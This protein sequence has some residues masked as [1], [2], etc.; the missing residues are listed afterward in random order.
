MRGKKSPH[1]TIAP[2][3]KFNKLDVA[4]LINYIMKD[5]KKFVESGNSLDG[6]SR[7]HFFYAIKEKNAGKG[8]FSFPIHA[9]FSI[10]EKKMLLQNHKDLLI[11]FIPD[12]N[13]KNFEK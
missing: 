10:T 12:R 2:D 1:R 13:L 4:K 6:I 9:S 11:F 3:P 5:G 7:K 8:G